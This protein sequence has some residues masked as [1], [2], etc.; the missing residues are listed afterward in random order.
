MFPSPACRDERSHTMATPASQITVHPAA[1]EPGEGIWFATPPGFTHLPLEVLTSEVS[2]Q[3]QGALDETLAP[4][5]GAAADEV[6]RERFRSGLAAVRPLLQAMRGGGT[7]HCSLGL[8]RDEEG[9]TA[10][11]VLR[12][13]F[14]VSWADTAWAPRGVTAARAVLTGQG[15][16]HIEY[17][18]VPCGP[19]TFSETLREPTPESGFPRIPLLQLHAHL[20][21]PDGTSLALLTLSTAA[22]GHREEYR[23]ILRRIADTV[24]FE[25]PFPDADRD[26]P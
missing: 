22:V 10:D 5:V 20:P 3:E 17:A 6:T 24:S 25:D 2:P 7:T 4:F 11:G 23:T 9:A 26:T 19:V 12:S 8:H 16:G 1:R 18:E 14:T 21:H 13:L 15:H